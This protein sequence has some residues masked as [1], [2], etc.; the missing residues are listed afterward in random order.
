MSYPTLLQRV[1]MVLAVIM[2]VT[3]VIARGAESEFFPPVINGSVRI[4]TETASEIQLVVG[5]FKVRTCTYRDSSVLVFRDGRWQSTRLTGKVTAPP[6]STGQHILGI[7]K[8]EALDWQR[9][10]VYATYECGWLWASL[11]DVHI[12]DVQRGQAI[13]AR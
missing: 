8:I 1:M 11:V 13:A 10:R 12:G 3:I 9:L 6:T 7:Y 4:V 2:S 5:A